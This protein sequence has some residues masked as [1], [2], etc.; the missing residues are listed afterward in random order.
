[1]NKTIAGKMI[2]REIRMC[3]RCPAWSPS[4]ALISMRPVFIPLGT[5]ITSSQKVGDCF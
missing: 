5:L 4:M 2:S 1:M 3:C